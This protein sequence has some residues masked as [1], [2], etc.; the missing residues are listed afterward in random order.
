MWR[1][2]VLT[3]AACWRSLQESPN[4]NLKDVRSSSGSLLCITKEPTNVVY[5]AVSLIAAGMGF[6]RKREG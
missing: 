1:T 3:A 6:T 4:Y 5:I 2:S